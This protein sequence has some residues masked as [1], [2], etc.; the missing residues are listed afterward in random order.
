MSSDGTGKIYFL[1]ILS[2]QQRPAVTEEDK[3]V[4]YRVIELQTATDRKVYDSNIATYACNRLEVK[5]MI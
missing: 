4:V 1:K 5:Q 2:L 3:T